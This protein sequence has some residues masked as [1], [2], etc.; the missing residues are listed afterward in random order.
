MV[1]GQRRGPRVA[2]L[3]RSIADY[4]AALVDQLVNLNLTVYV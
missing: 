1:V 3:A 4:Q 2:N